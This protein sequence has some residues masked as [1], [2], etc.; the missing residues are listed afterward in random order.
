M[1]LNIAD[2]TKGSQKVFEIDDDHKLL[3]FFEKRMGAEVPGD[4]LGE[5]FKGFV[6]RITGGNDKQGFPM[7][8]GVLQDRRVRLLFKK[9]MNCYRERRK[10]ML[11]RKSVRGCIVGSDLAIMNLV[12]VQQG[13][14]PLEGLTDAEEKAK[15]L[16]PKRASKLRKLFDLE[17]KD[18][19]T[20]YVVRRTIRE[21]EDGKKNGKSK[22]PKVQR[23]VTSISL[24]R[25]RRV[26][27]Q[28]VKKAQQS[29]EDA[30]AY[31]QRLV[32]YRQELREKRAAEVA[33]K[34][35]SK[36]VSAKK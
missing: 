9:G 8:Q 31:H 1:K 27:N 18:D 15:R 3:P 30:K 4:S 17:K 36:K 22:A 13:E 10:G 21:A 34:K 7:K 2:Q 23:L 5:Q 29:K 14:K 32:E 28:K 11:K 16:G 35:S 33:K 20:K 12:V 24:Q 6:F 19:V 26:K 25:K